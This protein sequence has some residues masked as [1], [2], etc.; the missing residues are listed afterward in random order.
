M[1]QGYAREALRLWLTCLD[2]LI[3]AVAHENDHCFGGI[4]PFTFVKEIFCHI[5]YENAGSRPAF[6]TQQDS[7]Q[8]LL[9]PL[10]LQALQVSLEQV[11]GSPALFRQ[12]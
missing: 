3:G 11:P 1:P 12:S 9:E 7:P 2:V 10:G 4:D 6:T 5:G 8:A